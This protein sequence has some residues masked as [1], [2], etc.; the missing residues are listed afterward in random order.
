MEAKALAAHPGISDTN[1]ANHLMPDWAASLLRPLFALMVQSAAMGALPTLRAAV[2][3]QAKGGDYFGPD[4]RSERGGYPL[5]VTSSE[6]SHNAADAEKLW[7][8]SE[9]LTGVHLHG[10][11]L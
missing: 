7:R 3:P 6:A 11:P 10:T 5:K 2:D 4:G 9:Q 8:V 1:L